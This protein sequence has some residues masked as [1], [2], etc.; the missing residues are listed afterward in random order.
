MLALAGAPAR[1]AAQ[2]SIPAAK[3]DSTAIA[4]AADTLAA[5]RDAAIRAD[6]ARRPSPAGAMIKSLLVPGLGQLTLGRKLTAAVFV[7]FEGA[8]LAMVIKS[9]RELNDARALSGGEETPLVLEKSRKREDWLVLMGI[10]HVLSGLEAYVS[11][12]LW[13]FPGEVEIR[14]LPGGVVAGASVPVRFR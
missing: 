6:S 1:L 4:K 10:N 11:A 2:D 5:P 12:H 8:T 13:D 7:A 14:A 3:P 9:Q